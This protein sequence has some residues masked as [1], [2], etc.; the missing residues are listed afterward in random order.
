[1]SADDEAR[2]AAYWQQARR[3]VQFQQG[4][5][6]S[7]MGSNAARA[8]LLATWDPIIKWEMQ[9]AMP[10]LPPDEDP[11]FDPFGISDQ[12]NVGR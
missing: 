3:R 1:V 5:F 11:F 2:A 9:N 7:I 10:Y 8:A 12:V 4:V 6:R